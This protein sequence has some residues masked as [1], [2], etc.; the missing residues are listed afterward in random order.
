MKNV[1]QESKADKE[2]AARRARAK[3]RR[4]AAGG[5]DPTRKVRPDATRKGVSRGSKESPPVV[6]SGVPAS[7]DLPVKRFKTFISEDDILKAKVTVK[8]IAGKISMCNEHHD[9]LLEKLKIQG[10]DHL[11]SEDLDSLQQN[12]NARRVD[13]LFHATDALIKL[14][15]N[16]IGTEGVLLYRCPVCALNRFDFIAQIARFLRSSLTKGKVQ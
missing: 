5:K 16:T 7:E 6:A 14:S 15:I 1:A 8:N 9:H 10:I 11:I 12:L 4:E 3:A 2:R 13:P